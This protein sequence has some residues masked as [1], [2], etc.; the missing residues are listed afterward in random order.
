MLDHSLSLSPV[1]MQLSECQR[2]LAHVREEKCAAMQMLR[3]K[4]EA[5]E[6]V[7]E[8]SAGRRRRSSPFGETFVVA[9]KLLRAFTV[10]A[11]A[12]V[13][14]SLLWRLYQRSNHHKKK[15]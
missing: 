13:D 1:G 9:M 10:T 2:E 3:G 15:R 8:T 11:A 4:E 12:E 7:A 14:P 6:Q 5:L